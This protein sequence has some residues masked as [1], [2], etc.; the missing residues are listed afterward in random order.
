MTLEKLTLLW[1]LEEKKNRKK[2]KSGRK[3]VKL[4]TKDKRQRKIKIKK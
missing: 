2:R 3:K 4:A 1:M